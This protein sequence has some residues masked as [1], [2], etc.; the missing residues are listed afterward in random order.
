MSLRASMRRL[1]ISADLSWFV[2]AAEHG[3]ETVAVP[4]G[5]VPLFSSLLMTA[6]PAQVAGV[7]QLCVVTPPV[8]AGRPAPVIAAAAR[9]LGIDEVY[10]VGGADSPAGTQDR[11]PGFPLYGGRAAAGLRH[12]GHRAV[13]RPVGNRGARRRG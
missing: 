7:D 8:A 9:L 11:R 10:A 2:E 1:P 12:R 4:A 13:A 5:E 6:V 3:W